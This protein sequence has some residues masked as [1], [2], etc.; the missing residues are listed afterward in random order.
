[1]S[2]STEQSR[3]CTDAP[4]VATLGGPGTIAAAAAAAATRHLRTAGDR[5]PTAYDFDAHGQLVPRDRYN[6]HAAWNA[7]GQGTDGGNAA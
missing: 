4:Q 6:T 3:T 1:M 7:F 2:Q 5:N